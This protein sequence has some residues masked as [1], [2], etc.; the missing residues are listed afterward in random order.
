[1]LTRVCFA[2]ICCA[3]FAVGCG[4]VRETEVMAYTAYPVKVDTSAH[5]S[6]IR[7]PDGQLSVNDSC[8]VT[9]KRLNIRLPAQYVNGRPIGFC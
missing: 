1:M 2:L 6:K 7:F 5:H 8:I 4:E 3:L 9:G